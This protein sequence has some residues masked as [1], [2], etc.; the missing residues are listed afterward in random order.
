MNKHGWGLRIELAFLLLF[1]ICLLISTIGLHRMGLV[2]NNSDGVEE[3]LSVYTRDT[4]N[5]NYSA[6]E[7]RVSTAARKYY[8]DR[9]SGYNNDSIIIS[10][11][12]LKYNGYLS[13]I[14]DSRNKECKGYAKV[15]S[16]GSV[17]SYIKCSTYRTAG[18]SEEYE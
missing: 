4:G 12:T 7:D 6:L 18:Y 15:L 1:L 3:D 2:G 17:I 13:P 8:S 11:D 9:Y 10:I 16:S 5:N 14:Y